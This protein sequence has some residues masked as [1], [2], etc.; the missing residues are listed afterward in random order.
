MT[1]IEAHRFFVRESRHYVLGNWHSY[2]KADPK[3]RA[4][5]RKFYSRWPMA[6]MRFMS[7]YLLDKLKSVLAPPKD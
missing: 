2:D 4:E 7:F 3:M 6:Y 1:L 5:I